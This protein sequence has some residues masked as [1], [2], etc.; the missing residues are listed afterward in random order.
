MSDIEFSAELLKDKS[1]EEIKNLLDKIETRAELIPLLKKDGRKGLCE[2]A[3]RLASELEETKKVE[4]MYQ[5]E[6]DLY[7]EGVELIAGVDEAGIGPLAGPV[8]SA[9]VILPEN[10]LIHNLDDSKKL[11]R[12]TR[13]KVA[14]H[15]RNTALCFGLGIVESEE[16][17][18]LNIY[19]AGLK[20]MRLAV[21]EL[22][23]DH[24]LLLV[25]AREIPNTD[26]PQKSIVRGDEKS[27]SIAAASNLAKVHRDNIMREYDSK[28]PEYGFKSHKGYPTQS[29]KKAIA[30]YGI[31]PIH[32]KSFKLKK[33]KNLFDEI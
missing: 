3:D 1:I 10:A 12:E 25:D 9:A 4:E 14:D 11:N 28:Y 16:I 24:D 33:K 32:R 26:C 29:H 7:S 22:K 21:D 23:V 15:I 30:E 2:L 31:C 19:Q 27:A 13:K 5:F 8:V 6:R 18:R 17:D 20:A